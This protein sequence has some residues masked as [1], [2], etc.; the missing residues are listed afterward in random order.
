MDASWG[1]VP[2]HDGDTQE[3]PRQAPGREVFGRIYELILDGQRADEHSYVGKTTRTIHQ[4]VHGRGGHTSA[5][6]IAKD[7]WKARILPGRAGYRQLELVYCTGEGLAADKAALARAEAFWIDRLRTVHNDVRPVR[8][9]EPIKPPRPSRRRP[10][11][12][13]RRKSR[14]SSGKLTALLLLFAV[15]T[16]VV[17]YVLMTAQASPPVVWVVSPAVGTLIS[18]KIFYAAHRKAQKI[19][20]ALR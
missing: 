9:P 20:R 10:A 14:R 12:T 16:S 17:A 1:A 4:R 6:S 15:F 2:A 18:W 8:P 5:A 7:P 11:P 13:A 3:I 19:R